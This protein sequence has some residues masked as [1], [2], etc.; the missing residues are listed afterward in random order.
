[1]VKIQP[2]VVVHEVMSLNEEMKTTAVSPY[3]F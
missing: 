1:M 2:G 3:E